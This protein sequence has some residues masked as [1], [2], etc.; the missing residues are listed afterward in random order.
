MATTTRSPVSS[1]PG[2][3]RETPTQTA[4]EANG[5]LLLT[6]QHATAK[7]VYQGSSMTLAKGEMR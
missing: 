1:K 5:Y 6:I 7:Q 4:E 2:S 3:G